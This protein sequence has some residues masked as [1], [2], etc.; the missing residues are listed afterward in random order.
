MCIRDRWGTILEPTPP[1]E[2]LRGAVMSYSGTD[3]LDVIG[4]LSTGALAGISAYSTLSAA[5]VSTVAGSGIAGLSAAGSIAW[6]LGIATALY[7][8]F[9]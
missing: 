5:K 6:P 3:A 1:P 7:S 8:I 2:P 9:N 4:G